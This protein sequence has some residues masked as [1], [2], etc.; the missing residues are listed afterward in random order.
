MHGQ[1]VLPAEDESH[2]IANVST[3]LRKIRLL[4]RNPSTGIL[5]I[6]KVS[7]QDHSVSVDNSTTIVQDKPVTIT[8]INQHRKQTKDKKN[9]G[10]AWLYIISS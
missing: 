6:I 4:L 9:D 2:T 10:S 5:T 1:F 7:A 8:V 3:F